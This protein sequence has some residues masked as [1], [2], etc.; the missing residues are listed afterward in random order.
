MA[1]SSEEKRRFL[2]ALEEDEEFRLA[3]AGLLGL[4]EILEEL[5]EL[6][7]G[8]GRLE[9]RQMKLEE[10]QMK[11]EERMLELEER[12][13]D[14]EERQTRLEERQ[15]EL[16]ERMLGL[17]ERQT[18]LEEEM[19]ETRRVLMVVS[20]R[21]G[22]LSETGFREGMRY[23]V[24][25]ALGAGKVERLRLRD[26][27]GLVYG[28][29]GEVE[30]DL[31]VRD[32]VHILVEVKSRVGAGDVAE[33]GRVGRLYERLRGVRPRLVLL[34]GFIERGAWRAAERLGVELRPILRE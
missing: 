22:V 15:T 19:R 32:G 33:L 8:Q 27:E 9:E 14:L 21:F 30:V 11:L 25:E 10:R 5:R 24:E 13:T 2:R 16:E 18:R 17:E 7:E 28:Y 4:R 34:G 12:M 23:V 29:P 3:V 6:R 31:L 26:E 1:L 20:H